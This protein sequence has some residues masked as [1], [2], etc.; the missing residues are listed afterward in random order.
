M[1][2]MVHPGR[3]DPPTDDAMAASADA[4][5]GESEAFAHAAEPFRRQ[6]K[7][8]CY[9]MTGSLHEAEDLVQETYLRAWRAFDGFEGRGSLKAWLYQIATRVCLDA[10]ARQKKGP[11]D[12]PAGRFPADER[13]AERAAAE[14]YRLAGALSGFGTGAACR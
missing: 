10:I 11:A 13:H 12:P 5:G 2:L 7:A 1:T 6:I 4:A 9:R 3:A 8:H 14:R